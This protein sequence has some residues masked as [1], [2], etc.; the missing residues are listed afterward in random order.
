MSS[1]F[2]RFMVGLLVSLIAL[3]VAIVVQA[4]FFFAED[5]HSIGRSPHLSIR[6]ITIGDGGRWALVDTLRR[7]P[8]SNRGF[9]YPVGIANLGRHPF[10]VQ[11]LSMT[12]TPWVGASAEESHYAF[13][14]SESGELFVFDLWIG[15]ASL[16]RLGKLTQQYPTLLECSADGSAVFVGGKTLARWDR[17]TAKEVW[18]RLDLAVLDVEYQGETD[19]LICVTTD[20]RIL[21]LDSHTGATVRDFSGHCICA[22]N[23]DVSPNGERLLVQNPMGYAVVIDQRT[24]RVPWARRFP[25]LSAVPRFS[26]DGSELLAPCPRR[27]PRIEILSAET[28]AYVAEL[29]GAAGEV[30]GIIATRKGLVYAW[31]KKGMLT[32]W[33]LKTRNR[34]MQFNAVGSALEPRSL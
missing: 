20:S 28:G 32:T 13:M 7:L 21:E 17:E 12:F 23:V 10:S 9:G 1:L 25:G 24:S 34:M 18:H 6:N 11:P 31:D 15:A 8:L 26:A 29:K 33:N 4:V 27:G 5:F 14:V 2:K 30:L 3:I 19:K 16:T 22:S